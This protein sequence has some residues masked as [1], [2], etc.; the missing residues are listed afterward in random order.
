MGGVYPCPGG[1]YLILPGFRP[2][3]GAVCT[4][5]AFTDVAIYGVVSSVAGF[6][7]RAPII[8]IACMFVRALS[9]R[10]IS[11]TKS[12]KRRGV[13]SIASAPAL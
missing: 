6:H 4:A 7:S 1:V 5:L 3:P 9:L 2:G 11:R 12:A 8:A 10:R 13:V